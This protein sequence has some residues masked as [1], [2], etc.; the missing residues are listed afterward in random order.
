MKRKELAVGMPV[1]IK[2]GREYVGY[3]DAV[4]VATEPWEAVSSFGWRRDEPRFRR[5][6]DGKG[7]GVAVAKARHERVWDEESKSY[8]GELITSWEP[9]VVQ[10]ATLLA[11]DQAAAERAAAAKAEEA[12]RAR[13]AE[14][15]ALRDEYAAALGL[16]RYQVHLERGGYS[17]TIPVSALDNLLAKVE[18]ATPDP[19]GGTP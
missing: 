11:P 9:E 1:V 5:T 8:T 2:R 7:N 12:K 18:A 17:V 6:R 19:E 16:K 4:I 14:D 10:L 15:E 13:K 3:S